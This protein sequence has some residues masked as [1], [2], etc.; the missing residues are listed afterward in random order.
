MIEEEFHFNNDD[1]E[2]SIFYTRKYYEFICSLVTDFF[3]VEL[4]QNKFHSWFINTLNSLE[5]SDDVYF[6][7]SEMPFYWAMCI[8]ENNRTNKSLQGGDLEDYLKFAKH[9]R[10]EK[11]IKTFLFEED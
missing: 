1:D 3:K 8:M 7:T 5:D 11:G 4:E 6:L 2:N 9:Y 10:N